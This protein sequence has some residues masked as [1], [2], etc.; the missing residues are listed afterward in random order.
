MKKFLRLNLL[1]GFLILTGLTVRTGLAQQEEY[2]LYLP[3]VAAE[4]RPAPTATRTPVPTRT[5]TPSPTPVVTPL[6]PEIYTTSYYMDN[7]NPGNYYNIGCSMGSR[8]RNLYGAQDSVV[9]FALGRPYGENGKYGVKIYNYNVFVSTDQ[10]IEAFQKFG[11]GYWVCSGSDRQSKVTV[12]FGTSNWEPSTAPW[13]SV[14][15]GDTYSNAYQHGKAWALMVRQVNEW[16]ASRGYASQVTAV[17]AIDMELSWNKPAPSKAWVAGFDANDQGK[18]AYYNFGDCAG[19][20]SKYY[21]G[22]TPNNGWTLDDIWY[23]SWGAPPAWPLPLI[24]AESGINAYQWQWVSR[25]SVLTYGSKILFKGPMTQRQAC[26]Q[27]GG[28]AYINNSPMMGW[29]QLWQALN[30]DSRTSQTSLPW[31][32]DIKYF[33]R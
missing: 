21:P 8:D 11:E 24:Y 19:C 29:S 2:R 3:L 17:G 31:S 18:Y 4:P 30:S 28:C 32:T 5:V 7:V 9:I 26:L 15:T 22:W 12:G 6:P 33:Y 27:V 13:F 10:M 23:T 25:Y 14:K 20:P 1:I 16:Y